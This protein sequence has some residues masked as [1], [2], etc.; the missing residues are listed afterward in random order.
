[1]CRCAITERHNDGLNGV[2]GE[3]SASTLST[4]SS[5][6]TCRCHMLLTH[7]PVTHLMSRNPSYVH[8]QVVTTASQLQRLAVSA[9]ATWPGVPIHRFRPRACILPRDPSSWR[10]VAAKTNRHVIFPRLHTRTA[11]AATESIISGGP[12]SC[13]C[14]WP[15]CLA[16]AVSFSILLPV[17]R[18]AVLRQPTHSWTAVAPCLGG[19]P[20]APLQRST[21]ALPP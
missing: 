13:Y 12:V 3:P 5:L 16:T 17:C 20:T 1:M 18:I 4:T 2:T 21:R 8:I 19:V 15:R 10:Q 6:W 9:T 7:V 14:A 11:H